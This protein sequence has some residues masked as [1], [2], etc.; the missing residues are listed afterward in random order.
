MKIK[1]TRDICWRRRRATRRDEEKVETKRLIA[2]TC[3]G[4]I[5]C[6]FQGRGGHS[7]E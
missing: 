4:D 1:S 7:E 6:E 3:N 5:H 2:N